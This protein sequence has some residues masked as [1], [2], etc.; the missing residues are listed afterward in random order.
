MWFYGFKGKVVR[1]F[2]NDQKKITCD[3]EMQQEIDNYMSAG[4]AS[5]NVFVLDSAD[6][7]EPTTFFLTRSK[8]QIMI[9]RTQEIFTDEKY[10]RDLE[11]E[12]HSVLGTEIML[13]RPNEPLLYL[14][15]LDVRT[16]DTFLLTMRM[17]Q[18]KVTCSPKGGWSIPGNT[19]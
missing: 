4:Q 3:Q 15:F 10:T 18:S 13:I 9:N 7:W 14:M 17:F 8:Y 1:V 19:P 16:R 6:S 12:L 2:A 11:I 5:F